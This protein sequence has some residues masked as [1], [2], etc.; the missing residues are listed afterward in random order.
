MNFTWVTIHVRDMETSL[1][2]YQEIIGLPLKRRFSPGGTTELAFLGNAGESE[3]ELFFQPGDV[4]VA[5]E[6]ISIGFTSNVR[7][8]DKIKAVERFGCSVV[9][10]IISPGPHMRF[11]H[12]SDP[13]GYRVQLIEDI[14]T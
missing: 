9:S 4:A 2:F 3:L 10:P 6:G 5:S 7:L 14:S 12:V 11:V 1:K 13:D 8:E